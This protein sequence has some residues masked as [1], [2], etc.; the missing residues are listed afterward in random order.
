MLKSNGKPAHEIM[1]CLFVRKKTF[2]IFFSKV[3]WRFLFNHRSDKYFITVHSKARQSIN[4]EVRGK[5]DYRK[6]NHQMN[7]AF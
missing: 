4:L 6:S 3:M 5:Q 7:R 2:Y 1:S